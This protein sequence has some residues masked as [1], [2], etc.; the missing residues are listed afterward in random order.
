LARELGADDYG[1][2]QYVIAFLKRGPN[3]DLPEEE[4][5]TLQRA[6]LDNSDLRGVY[7]FNVKLI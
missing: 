2:K 5:M 4:A 7:I 1:M 6:H 3:R